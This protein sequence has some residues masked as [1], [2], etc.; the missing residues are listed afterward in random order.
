MTGLSLPIDY[1]KKTAKAL[2]KHVRGAESNACRRVRTVFT[3]YRDKPDAAVASNFTL[4]QAQHVVAVEHGFAK[5]QDLA[6]ASATELRLAITMVKFPDLNAHGVGLY[7]HHDR[8]PLA[9]RE[10][11]FT[12]ERDELR[13][14]ADRVEATVQWLRKHIRAIKSINLNHTSYGL[15]HITEQEIGY[16][17][18]G[19]FIA[20]AIIA[21]Y[22]FRRIEKPKLAFG[23]SERSIKESAKRVGY[24]V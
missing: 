8:L 9:E 7:P 23:M 16:I 1:F 3:N 14:S 4:M 2:H 12:D 11:F 10:K 13:R 20:A 15:K 21:G 17:P 24:A 19:V 6:Q 22:P 18:N 5:W